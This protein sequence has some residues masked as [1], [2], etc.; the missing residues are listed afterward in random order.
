MS[1]EP[2]IAEPATNTFVPAAAHSGERVARPG[3]RPSRPRRSKP[4]SRSQRTLGSTSGMNFWP[5][6]P[7]KTLI[8]STRS[9]VVQERRRTRSTWRVGVERHADARHAARRGSARI[10]ARAR[11]GAGAVSTWKVST[12]APASSE[13]AGV[14]QRVGDHQ[15][16]VERALRDALGSPPRPAARSSGWARSARPSRPR[17]ASRPPPLHAPRPRRRAGRSRRTGATARCGGRQRHD[18]QDSPPAPGGSRAAEVPA[19]AGSLRRSARVD[20]LDAG[21][22]LALEQ[23]ER[24]AAAGRDVVDAL[25]QPEQLA[26]PR[27]SRRRRPPC[28]RCTRPRRAPI[29]SVPGAEG[30]H[31]EHAHRTVPHDRARAA[32]R[33]G[34]SARACADRCRGPSSPSGMSTAATP[35]AR[36][37]PRSSRRSRGRRAA[38]G[39]RRAARPWRARR[40]PSRAG[41]PRSSELPIEWPCALQEG[42]GHAAAD[43]QRVDLVE[44]AV[45]HA[46]ACRRPSRRR[47]SRRSGRS[48]VSS[49]RSKA[50]ISASISRPA[51]R[52]QQARDARH[53]GSGRGA[54]C[55][56]RRS[57]NTSP[58]LRVAARELRVALRLSADGSARS[59]A[60]RPRRGSASATARSTSGPT[61]AVELDAPA[62]RAARSSR[63]AT[64]SSRHALRRLPLGRPRWLIRIGRPPLSSISRMV[65]SAA[66]MRVSSR[67]RAALVERHVEVDAHEHA[68]ARQ[69]ERVEVASRAAI[70]APPVSPRATGARAPWPSARRRGSS[71]PT[72]CRTRRPPSPSRRRSPSSTARR[73][74]SCAGCR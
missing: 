26:R 34:R 11:G 2:K 8:T 67:D 61:L 10:T 62:S 6:K 70:G 13:G 72:R 51:H 3:R 17:A 43:E 25:R 20:S 64:G 60:A 18:R 39:R 55:R 50:R 14:L 65:G 53:R 47:G 5:P 58:S 16:H 59:R 30:R 31:L 52:R 68:L 35:C 63:A 57:T 73:R 19:R 27:P 71:S 29:A 45:D 24:G 42:V 32:D 38:A 1:S 69:V 9:S 41:P 49:T 22:R 44:Q 12:C 37:R 36:R 28:S 15:V 48:G 46:A 66:R 74:P 40:A 56:R 7:G 4:R 21:Q 54:S 33:A 23:L